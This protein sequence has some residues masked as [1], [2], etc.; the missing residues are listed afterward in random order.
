[1]KQKLLYIIFTVL[2]INSCNINKDWERAR[3]VFYDDFEKEMYIKPCKQS[4]YN[5]VKARE[6]E[7]G[8]KIIL[9]PEEV[10]LIEAD[11]QKYMQMFFDEDKYGMESYSFGR[12]LGGDS[13]MLA[14]TK[15]QQKTCACKTSGAFLKGYFLVCNNDILKIKTDHKK[16]IYNRREIYDFVDSRSKYPMTQDINTIQD[17]IFFLE[18]I[19]N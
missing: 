3:V 2:I 18:N 16:N 19:N 1:M 6:I 17:L 4:Y 12:S 14:E 9:I 11:S 5:F 8:K 15:F 13:I 10:K 7:T